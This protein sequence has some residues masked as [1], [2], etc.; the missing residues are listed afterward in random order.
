M[1]GWHM[2]VYLFCLFFWKVGMI[3]DPFI[4]SIL[5][6]MGWIYIGICIVVILSVPFIDYTKNENEE[7]IDWFEDEPDVEYRGVIKK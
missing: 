1:S 2:L 6:M 3:T 5:W 4:T 7:E